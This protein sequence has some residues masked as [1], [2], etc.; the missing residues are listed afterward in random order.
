MS[1]N[2]NI[3]VDS[4]N[5]TMA[6]KLLQE[7]A[8]E[9]QQKKESDKKLEDE[10]VK[11]AAAETA[12]RA[13]NGQL[14]GQNG[15]GQGGGGANASDERDAQGNLIF[16]SRITMPT[17]DRRPAANRRGGPPNFVLVPDQ[18]FVLNSL[19]K[20]TI[21]A[22]TKGI[23]NKSFFESSFTDPDFGDIGVSAEFVSSGGPGGAPYLR[24]PSGPTGVGFYNAYIEFPVCDN[25]DVLNII[26]DDAA[27][28]SVLTGAGVVAPKQVRM[29]IHKLK[30]YTVEAY[31]KGDVTFTPQGTIAGKAEMGI[32]S[33]EGANV[34]YAFLEYNSFADFGPS[35]YYYSL[36]V[37]G[38]D[39]FEVQIFFDSYY[40]DDPDG[41]NASMPSY[42]Y[43]WPELLQPNEWYHLALVKTETSQNLY[44][45]GTLIAS[46]PTDFSS[47]ADLSDEVI[48]SA[49]AYFE[50]GGVAIVQP[51]LSGFRFTPR[52]LYTEPFTPPASITSLA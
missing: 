23:K 42:G 51:G 18:D 37:Q 15:A 32:Y 28:Y 41:P 46:V 6:V 33:G 45:Q 38:F 29:P 24:L 40:L 34:I 26:Y 8:R 12:K 39:G 17:I 16:G 43:I 52:A 31:F 44:F 19:S 5:L 49:Y 21:A 3:T 25:A 14:L 47:L 7:A 13:K 30:N 11:E 50:N 36:Y 20:N 27:P 4:S 35:S 2:I 10:A 1:T 22:K 9:A 48:Y